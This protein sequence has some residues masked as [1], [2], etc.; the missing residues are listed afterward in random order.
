MANVLKASKRG[1]Y[2]PRV[3]EGLISTG[4]KYADWSD[5]QREQFP[6]GTMPPLLNTLDVWQGL[7][8]ERVEYQLQLTEDEVIA[9]TGKWLENI[10]RRRAQERRRASFA[11][12]TA[13]P[14]RGAS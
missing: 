2:L 13:S 5:E 8:A 10:A 4:E 12:A 9:I 3:V 11:A 1:R 7:G 14:V 6:R